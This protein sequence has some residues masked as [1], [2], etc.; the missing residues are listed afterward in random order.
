LL[1]HELT[2]VLQQSAFDGIR[3][4]QNSE[5]RGLLSPDYSAAMVN[6]A[7][8]GA[9]HAPLI[10]T[11]LTIAR[12]PRTGATG[13]VPPAVKT[14]E[15]AS[16]ED[17]VTWV[18]LHEG[19][20]AYLPGTE[21]T[22]DKVAAYVSGHPDMPD[23]LAKLNGVSR[24]TPIPKTKPIVIPIEFIDRAKAIREMPEHM[25]SR[26][27]SMLVLRTQQAQ[28]QRFV[29]VKSGHPMGPG[30]FGLI[31]V[32]T[33]TLKQ[34]GPSLSHLGKVV[35]YAVAFIAGVIDG[36]LSS[37]WDALSGIAEMA[38]SIV[39]S[40]FTLELVS[41]IKKLGEAIS[42]L[43]W[44]D[45]RQALGEWATKWDAKLKSDSPW[46]AAHAH[47]YLTGYVMA[48][49]AMLL[50]SGGATAELK[51]ALWA[52]RLGQ[53]VKESQALRTLAS[54]I[55][56]AGQASE[57]TRAVLARTQEALAKTKAAQALAA[58]QKAIGTALRLPSKMVGELSAEAI[59]RLTQLTEPLRTRIRDLSDRA[60]LWL[61][62]C[63]SAC[64]V[65]IEF[66]RNRL[67]RMTNKEIDDFVAKLDEVAETPKVKG[68]KIDDRRV[69]TGKV[70]RMEAE[71][72]PRI[73]KTETLEQ[74]IA[75]I[76]TVIVK[77]VADD[78]ALR[79]LWDEAASEVM[80]GQ[81]LT[82]SN[83]AT[84]YDRTRNKFWQKVRD[85]PDRF[86]NAGFAFPRS[87][88]RAPYL[89][90]MRKNIPDAEITISLDHSAEKA[91]ASN[92]KRALDPTN[93]VYEFAAPNSWREIIQMRHPVLRP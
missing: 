72:I 71:D 16:L 82:K 28:Y 74:A 7:V 41:D 30:A 25:R 26:I 53:A 85:N 58:A 29:R 76:R 20:F 56:K 64:K 79:K 36:F 13:A 88:Q 70:R 51:G 52:T 83:A 19:V 42:G 31:P 1:A 2:H 35:A 27:A 84:M 77:T 50:L 87:E 75:R 91:I 89:R 23:A 57:K 90:G 3:V 4:G 11:G 12:K 14:S 73:T 78:P 40:V 5:K 38:F 61:F 81:R 37:L 24:Q 60:K 92:W 17:Q 59:E 66:M 68:G 80:R 39:K 34:I 48:E 55:E 86:R 62:G 67:K 21:T 69:P 9:L 43:T 6:D 33:E 46:V 15:S 54:G 63:N 65:D 44:A 45:F 49:A 8:I 32:T 93:L 10:G 22:V 18:E 47:G